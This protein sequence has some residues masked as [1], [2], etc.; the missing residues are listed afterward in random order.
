LP[1]IRR[2]EILVIAATGLALFLLLSGQSS[3]KGYFS[4]DTLESQSQDFYWG[5]PGVAKVN[6]HRLTEY[7]VKKGY[8]TR[9]STT[10]PRWLMTGHYSAQWRDGH[11]A[12]TSALFW[13][14]DEWIEWS[15]SHPKRA[16]IL[17]PRVLEIL[18]SDRAESQ[19]IVRELLYF[20]E[21]AETDSEFDAAMNGNTYQ[22]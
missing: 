21:R 12:L 6:R 2:L 13:H 7:L 17:W 3:S 8:W 4:P 11:S 1:T 5:I 19:S 10:N 14:T 22:H 15:E 16:A 18:R 20:V 9:N